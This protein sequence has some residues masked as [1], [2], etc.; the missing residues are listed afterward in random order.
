MDRGL[1]AALEAER[2]LLGG[3]LLREVNMDV[4]AGI[5]SADDFYRGAH[6]LIYAAM[7]RLHDVGT[8]LDLVTVRA[9]LKRQGELD[10]VGGPAYISALVDGVPHSANVAH[11]AR[12]VKEKANLRNIIFLSNKLMARAYEGEEPSALILTDADRALVELQA[13]HGE[14]G[15]QSLRAATDGLLADLEYRNTHR[16]ELTGVDTGFKSINEVTGGWQ[17]GDVV[18][19]AARP[20]I[21]KTTLAIN[22]MVAGARAGAKA[23]IFSLEMKRK[24]LEYRILSSI[25]NVPLARLLK[26]FVLPTEWALVANAVS[27]MGTLPIHIDDTASMSAWDI[28]RS[29]RRLKS[30]GG[31]DLVIIDY[32]QLMPGTIERRGVTRNEEITDISRRLKILAGDLGVCIILL[33][34]LKRSEGVPKLSDLR[35]SGALEQDADIVGLLHRKNHR[36]GGET[37]FIIEKQRNGPTG[38]ISLSLDRDV[39]LFTDAGEALEEPQPAEQEKKK[40]R[41]RT[42]A[43]KAGA[44]H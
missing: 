3:L 40:A 14:T 6:K 34:Q 1:P 4:V 22:T 17:A 18:I 10:E 30:D 42:F 24:Q 33:S 28:R 37:H 36:E 26:G 43:R 44:S 12:I 9:D 41:Q 38:T 32:V 39:T 7:V 23:A 25:S 21:G 15:M 5:M 13:G 16:G 27:E 11:Y 20:S 35:E 29:C 8:A 19:V 2:T 31:L